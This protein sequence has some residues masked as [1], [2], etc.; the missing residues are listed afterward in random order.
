MNRH[1]YPNINFNLIIFFFSVLY[2]QDLIDSEARVFYD[3]NLL[4]EDG[5]IALTDSKFSED[6]SLYAFALSSSGSDWNSIHF[7]DTKTGKKLPEVLE[8]VKYSSMSWTHDNKGIF[9]GVSILSYK[10]SMFHKF[11]S[12]DCSVPRIVERSGGPNHAF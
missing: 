9:Y 12:E 5:T 3:P 1:I 6:G 11:S 10:H 8:K 7:I 4:S 2:V